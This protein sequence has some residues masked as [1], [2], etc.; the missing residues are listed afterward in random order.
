MADWDK[1]RE[2]M[3]N[4][5][6]LATAYDRQ[7]AEEQTA[8]IRAALQNVSLGKESLIL[9]V[10]CGTGM[11]FTHTREF[12]GL[13][14]GADFSFKL[15]RQAKKR[16]KQFLNGAIVRADADHLP[17]CDQTFD[18]IFAVTLLQNMPNPLKTLHEM[19]RVCKQLSTLV[20]TGLQKEFS[21]EKFG[22]LLDEARLRIL[23]IE[24]KDQLKD[25]VAICRKA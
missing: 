6:R 25:Y 4:Y 21:Q 19:E 8:K 5:D 12:A 7:Y 18:V 2:V 24:T 3:H 1:K 10:G 15:L 11:L 23:S 17:F 13:L 16:A 14:V 9:D 22:S 20:V